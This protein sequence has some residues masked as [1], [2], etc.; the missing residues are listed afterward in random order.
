MQLCNRRVWKLFN[1]D[2]AVFGQPVTGFLPLETRAKRIN[3]RLDGGGTEVG[4][5]GDEIS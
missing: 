2:G 3:R 5:E 4:R 1:K